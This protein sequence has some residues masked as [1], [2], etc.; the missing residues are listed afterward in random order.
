MAW[1]PFD[2]AGKGIILTGGAG[3]LGAAMTVCMLDAGATVAIIGRDSRKLGLVKE[4]LGIKGRE[5][6][7]VPGNFAD[8]NIIQEA[9]NQ[10]SSRCGSVHGLVNNAS[11][12][13]SGGFFQYTR[14]QLTK[15]TDNLINTMMVTKQV[16]D[17][18][19]SGVEKHGGSIVN[20]A[21]MYGMVSPHPN[22]YQG[23]PEWHSSAAYGATKAGI[24]QFS[25]YSAI[26]LAPHNIRVNSLSPGPFPNEQTQES[27][28]FIDKL[29]NQTPLERIGTPIE[30]ATSVVFLLSNAASYITGSNLVVDG[31]WTAW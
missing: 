25:K 1:G 18:M 16:T 22:V 15:T 20:I 10:I 8:Q 30:V 2:L 9:I 3:H 19:I 14:E 31:G 27:A 29:V 26:H 21:S 24:I 5:V 23:N 13:Q 12:S 11:S 6:I 7:V 4:S 28:Q 17:F